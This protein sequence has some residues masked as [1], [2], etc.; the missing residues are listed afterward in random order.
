M[1]STSS[2]WKTTKTFLFC[3]TVVCLLFLS[4]FT[5]ILYSCYFLSPSSRNLHLFQA[6][7]FIQELSWGRYH[8]R[9]LRCEHWTS[10]MHWQLSRNHSRFS[11]FI[12]TGWHWTQFTSWQCTPHL[13]RALGF[14]GF[15]PAS[16][17]PHSLLCQALPLTCWR[18]PRGSVWLLWRASCSTS[19]FVPVPSKP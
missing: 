8:F 16:L 18:G 10:Q 15:L 1:R 14:P 4:P 19:S 7:S 12:F 5:L 3:Q 13:L 6:S 17:G 9:E 2:I 11:A